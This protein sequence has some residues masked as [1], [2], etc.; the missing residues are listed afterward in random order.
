M[1]VAQTTFQDARKA[2][3]AIARSCLV[4]CAWF[5]G[6]PNWGRILDALGYSEPASVK[7]WWIFTTTGL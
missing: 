5:G 1:F 7:R 2:S 3:R 4:K 6:D